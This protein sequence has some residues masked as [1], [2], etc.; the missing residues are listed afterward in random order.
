MKQIRS[1]NDIIREREVIAKQLVELAKRDRLKQK[2][3]SLQYHPN[4]FD[5][6]L[7]SSSSSLSTFSS[8]NPLSNS[9]SLSPSLQGS[10]NPLYSSPTSNSSLSGDSVLSGRSFA[11]S[12]PTSSSS[13]VVWHDI[14]EPVMSKAERS[15]I[16]WRVANLIEPTI[17]NITSMNELS[18]QE[19]M[20]STAV[21]FNQTHRTASLKLGSARSN[22]RSVNSSNR[23]TNSN[24]S[25]GNID[26]QDVD[27]I[28]A[29]Q[30]EIQD[31]SNDNDDTDE[32]TPS[33]STLRLNTERNATRTVNIQQPPQSSLIRQSSVAETTATPKRGILKRTGPS[34]N[35]YTYEDEM[36]LRRATT[37][38]QG[39]FK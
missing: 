3:E 26:Q 15:K 11:T 13:S 39:S 22:I 23:S 8:I 27:H 2:Q 6:S 9:N 28:S 4:P 10:I 31:T 33:S 35:E 20:A 37:T 1:R 24:G 18:L 21:T 25:L 7:S 19:L 30:D 12:T 14:Y 34:V 29:E 32:P 17:E 16:R 36:S 38:T 5:Y